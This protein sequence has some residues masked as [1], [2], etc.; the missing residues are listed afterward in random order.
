MARYGGDEFILMLPE[1]D[2]VSAA[3]ALEKIAQSMPQCKIP[4]SDTITES[5]TLSYGLAVY[6]QD[7]QDINQLITLADKNLYLN[8][9]K[10]KNGKSYKGSYNFV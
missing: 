6:P 4:I 9:A 1:I 10:I 3:A 8:K 2:P 7:S 5:L